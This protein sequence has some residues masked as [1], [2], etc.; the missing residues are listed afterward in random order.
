MQVYAIGKGPS[1]ASVTASPK[2]SVHGSRVLVEGTVI[3]ISAG[4]KQ[5]EQAARFPNGVPAV[6][7][8][9]MGAWMEYVY[10]QKPRP[11]DVMGVEVVISVVDPNNNCY[12]VGRATSEENGMFRVVFTPEVP[13][14]YSVYAS[15]EGSESYWPSQA[16]TSIDVEEAPAITPVPTPVPQEPVGTYFTVSTILIIIAIAIIGF[17]IL[18]KR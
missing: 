14:E 13:G 15:F 9:S 2:V 7:D 17:L 8:A 18:R 11:T 4:T 6:S 1:A 16:V 3:D 5:N 10:M 12:E